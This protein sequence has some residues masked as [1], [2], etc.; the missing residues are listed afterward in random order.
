MG[1]SERPGGAPAS[2]LGDVAGRCRGAARGAKPEVATVTDVPRLI[3]L[4][5]PPGVG[6]STVARRFIADHPLAFCLDV[7]GVRRLIG[8]WAEHPMESGLLARKM[9]LAMA[10]EHL[11]EGHDVIV[12]QYLGRAAF[13][14]QL[15]QVA[16]ET[17]STFHEVVLIDTR[18]N[19]IAR[20][21]AR[22]DDPDLRTH[23]FEALA[24]TAGDE[25]LGEMYDRLVALLVDRPRAL[26][27][28]T[29][30]GRIDLAYRAL[31][32]QVNAVDRATHQL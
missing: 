27:I 20:F 1:R 2:G 22:A 12:P 30:A 26:Q 3:L 29:I 23:H 10:T 11:L 17:G 32:A 8:R 16:V 7:D 9:A 15:E 28:R 24:M 25:E 19:A 13:I 6:K 31:V 21:H 5:G 4:N 14:E 18:A